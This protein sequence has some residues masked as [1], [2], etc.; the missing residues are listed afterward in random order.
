MGDYSKA[1]PLLIKTVEIQ[2]QVV[3]E[4]HPDYA[5]SLK[6]LGLLY[7]DMGDYSKLNLY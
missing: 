4:N 1:E 6:N 5:D 7:G 3:G 2:R